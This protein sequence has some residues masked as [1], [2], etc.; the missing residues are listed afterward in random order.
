MRTQPT[1]T[2][3]SPL[4]KPKRE[5]KRAEKQEQQQ[6]KK[7]QTYTQAEATPSLNKSRVEY[8]IRNAKYR[9]PRVTYRETEREQD[10]CVVLHRNRIKTKSVG[11]H[12][13]GLAAIVLCGP[14]LSEWKT[15][16]LDNFDVFPVDIL[17]C[18]GCVEQNVIKS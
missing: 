16:R 9:T 4:D 5:E 6:Q 1:I 15:G 12:Y 14:T 11:R 2:Q 10:L 13:S 18:Y 7:Q 8:Q 17:Q 3:P